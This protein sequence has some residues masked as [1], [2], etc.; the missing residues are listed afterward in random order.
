MAEL[1]DVAVVGEGLAFPEGP[2]AMA[3]GSVLVVEVRA[4]RLARVT[5]R[6]TVERVADVGGGPNGAARGPDGAIYVCNN[7]GSVP[8]YATGPSGIQRVDLD[9]G[10]VE[11]IY[12]DCDGLALGRPNDLVFD[13]D[14]NFWFTDLD[15]GRIYYA[16]PDGSSI[17]C[18]WSD[19][20]TPNG[21][22]LSP[23]QT[24]LYVALTRPRQVLRRRILTPGELEPS[25]GYDIFSFVRTGELNRGLMLAGLAGAQELDSLAVD[26]TGAVC[27]GTL[28]ESGITVISAD[29]V[30]VEKH[31]LPTRL[32]DPAVTNL[33][34]GGTDMRTA[35]VTLGSTGRLISCRW[36]VPGLRLNFQEVRE[37]SVT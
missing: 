11:F 33:C 27:V 30:T 13:R 5:P 21:I 10:A 9:T 6:G 22:G 17:R 19:V 2:V 1:Q 25:A 35:F 4:G 31:T 8:G 7:G 18:V 26:S 14:G 20:H 28:V 32:A 36:P 24:T 37:T 23:D 29:G 3:D 12:R 16:A 34:F 15:P